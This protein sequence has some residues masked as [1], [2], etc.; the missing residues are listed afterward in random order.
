LVERLPDDE[1]KALNLDHASP[2]VPGVSERIPVTAWSVLSK[3][4]GEFLVE[5][6][7]EWV[8]NDIGKVFVQMFD[9]SLGIWAGKGASL[10]VFRET[11]GAAMVMEHNGDLYSCDHYVYPNFKLGNILNTS[12]GD[13]ARSAEQIQFGEAKRDSLP[14]YCKQCEVRFACNGE[15]PKHRFIKTPSGEPGLNYLCSAYKR[16][17][18][19]VDP[20][21]RA[22]TEL[23]RQGVAP[24]K[25]MEI[26]RVEEQQKR[27]KEG[28][29]NEACP[30][31]SG[32]KRKKCHPMD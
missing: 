12:L 22:M 11:C 32:K 18:H 13:L 31:G 23:L 10:C 26:L 21:M 5:I 9:V 4:Y 30:C 28:G 16:Y 6:F 3:D 15:C 2:P 25:L 8:R 29:P 19:H 7:D 20:F 24:A 27:W 17:F 14:D 1:A